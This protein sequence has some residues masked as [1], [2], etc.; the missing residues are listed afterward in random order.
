LSR[1]EILCAKFH[2]N[3]GQSCKILMLLLKLKLCGPINRQ[4]RAFIA[5]CSP[6][7]TSNT[8]PP[9]SSL[10]PPPKNVRFRT[11]I[12]DLELQIHSVRGKIFSVYFKRV[13]L[14]PFCLENDITG[15]RQF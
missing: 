2:K 13:F 10:P 7:M 6:R 12:K 5:S 14:L 4:D 3:T 9:P 1:K 11:V 8:S 15:S